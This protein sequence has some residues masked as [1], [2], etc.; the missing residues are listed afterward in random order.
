MQSAEHHPQIFRAHSE[1]HWFVFVLLTL[2]LARSHFPDQELILGHGGDSPPSQP[3]S[4]QGTLEDHC[5]KG[6][7][8][9]DPKWLIL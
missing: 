6:S 2:W 8:S 5:F 7:F 9:T 3:L 4:Y 1:D